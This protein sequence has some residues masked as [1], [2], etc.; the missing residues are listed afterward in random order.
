MNQLATEA[1]KPDVSTLMRR[2]GDPKLSFGQRLNSVRDVL[3]S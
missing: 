3:S 2:V 1:R